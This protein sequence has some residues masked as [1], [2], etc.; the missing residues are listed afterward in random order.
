M[1]E[2]AKDYN[3]P[4]ELLGCNDNRLSEPHLLKVSKYVCLIRSCFDRVTM[5]DKIRI[6]IKYVCCLVLIPSCL[7][8][9]LCGNGTDCQWEGFIFEEE[10]TQINYNNSLGGVLIWR[11]CNSNPAKLILNPCK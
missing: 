11:S 8:D 10:A 4:Q 1:Y 2:I 9:Q 6:L 3:L 5:H 7:I